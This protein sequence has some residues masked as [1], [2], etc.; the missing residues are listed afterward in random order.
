MCERERENDRV[1]QKSTE[2]ERNIEGGGP[3]LFLLASLLHVQIEEKSIGFVSQIV[4]FLD[5]EIVNPPQG[6]QASHFDGDG[7][8]RDI[9]QR[10]WTGISPG[11]RFTPTDCT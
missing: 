7:L 9:P 6:S 1:C 4:Q 10:I 5:H 2:L 11:R 8:Q 3:S